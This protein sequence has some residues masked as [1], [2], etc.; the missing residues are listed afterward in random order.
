MQHLELKTLLL[1]RE[2]IIRDHE[3]RD[4][5]PNEHLTALAN[6]SN[7]IEIWS[8]I[9]TPYI[10]ARL[11]HYLQNAS[12]TKALAHIE[13]LTSNTNIKKSSDHD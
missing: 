4:R 2:S 6:I 10:D 12:F 7:T 11:R 13:Y 9:N 1:R 5:Q 8:Q 3:W